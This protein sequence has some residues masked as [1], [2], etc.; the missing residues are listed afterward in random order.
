M[1]SECYLSS[2]Q[3]KKMNETEELKQFTLYAYR[4]NMSLKM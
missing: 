4:S 3:P 2:T 1:A